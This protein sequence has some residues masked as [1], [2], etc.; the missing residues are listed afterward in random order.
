MR[1]VNMHVGGIEL[2]ALAVNNFLPP[3]WVV[4]LSIGFASLWPWLNK[5][6]IEPSTPLKFALSFILMGIGF[7][8]FYLGC[9]TSTQTGLI[10]LVTFI[11]GYFFIISGEM[12]LSPIGLS[13]VTKLAPVKI[14]SMMMGIWFFASAIGEFLAAKIGALMSVPEAIAN[15]N[16]PATSLPF[17]ANILSKI[18]MGSIAIGLL[19]VCF[20]PVIRRWMA[21]IR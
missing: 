15:A 17:Y 21:D 6:G 19:L 10:P 16:N 11:G 14:V 3:G 7:Y 20:V 5:K 4:I 12:C 8:V 2:P 13:M 18:G 9:A 1:N